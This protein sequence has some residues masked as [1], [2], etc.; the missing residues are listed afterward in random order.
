MALCLTVI[1]TL[2]GQLGFLGQGGGGAGEV[3]ASG[4]ARRGRR[5]G[6]IQGGGEDEV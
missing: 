2:N 6:M 1:Y 5:K 4:R 3:R